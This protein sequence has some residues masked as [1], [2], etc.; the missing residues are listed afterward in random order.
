MKRK[1][2]PLFIKIYYEI[3]S[4]ETD[5]LTHIHKNSHKSTG[6]GYPKK[7]MIIREKSH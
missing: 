3:S 1:H 7:A 2:M 6:K 5:T 4:A